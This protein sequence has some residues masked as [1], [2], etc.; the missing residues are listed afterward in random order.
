MKTYK[1]NQTGNKEEKLI[2]PWFEPVSNT[3]V[4]LSI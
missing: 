1:I 3:Q 4:H 2:D